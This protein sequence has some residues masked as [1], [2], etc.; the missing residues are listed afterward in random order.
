[1]LHGTFLLF[2]ETL[3][4]FNHDPR[5]QKTNKKKGGYYTKQHCSENWVIFYEENVLCFSI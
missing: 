2:K 5:L 4:N 3:C 1:M